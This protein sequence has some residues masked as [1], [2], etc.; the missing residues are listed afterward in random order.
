MKSRHLR[1][2]AVAVL[3]VALLAEVNGFP[4][5]RRKRPDKRSLGADEADNVVLDPNA[6][7]GDDGGD[8]SGSGTELSE[9]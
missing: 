2:L 4:K 6:I 9:I 7:D 1:A 5:R 8:D 3:V